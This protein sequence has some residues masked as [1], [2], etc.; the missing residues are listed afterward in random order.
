LRI[1]DLDPEFSW[2]LAPGSWLLAPKYCKVIP[3]KNRKD[4][5]K[6]T[7]MVKAAG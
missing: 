5:Y 2:L 6:L 3:M 7:G 1:I 4:I